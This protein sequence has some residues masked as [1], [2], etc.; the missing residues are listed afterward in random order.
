MLFQ[1]TITGWTV[2]PGE[3]YLASPQFLDIHWV[4]TTGPGEHQ[5]WEI[6]ASLSAVRVAGR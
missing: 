3:R 1:Q 6:I 5:M 2:F 4:V